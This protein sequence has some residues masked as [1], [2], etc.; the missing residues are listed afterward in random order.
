MISFSGALYCVLVT[1]WD[2]IH[3]VFTYEAGSIKARVYLWLNGSTK[4]LIKLLKV[5]RQVSGEAGI[6]MLNF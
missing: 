5:I 3:V 1:E 2:T 6:W 4:E